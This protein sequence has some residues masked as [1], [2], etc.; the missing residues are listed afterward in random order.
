[1]KKKSTSQ[2]AFF[3]LRILVGV[4][5][6]LAGLSLALLATANPPGRSARAKRVVAPSPGKYKVTT[7]S[8]MDPLVP[9][10]F[11][12]SRIKQLG[13]DRQENFRAGAIMM[14]CGQFKGVKTSSH[15]SAFS[16]LV[17]NL[18][19]PLVY[20]ATDVDLITGDKSFPNVTQSETFT[21]ANPDDPSQVVVAYN[22]SRGRNF[23]P[24]NISGASFS[25]DGGTTFTRL[26]KA[27]GQSPFD[28]TFGDPV[29]LY[30][31]PSGTW[32][33][34]WL[35]GACGG[36]GLG[37]YSST[38][39]DD[40]DSW[41]HF[42]AFNEGS[43]DRESGWADNNPSSP[44]FGRL[45]ISWN[46]FNIGQGALMSIHSTDGGVTWSSPATVINGAT[47][48]RDV[49]ITGDLAGSGTVYIAGMDEGGGGFP[50]NDTNLIFKS[51]DG[52]TTWANTYTGTPFPGPGVTAQGYFA[53]M[54]PDNA[55]YWRHEGWG[56]PAAINNF[57]HLVYSQQGAPGDP[58]DVYYIRSTDG[59]VTFATPFKL[60]TDSTLRPQWQANLS[61]SPTGTLLATWY[62][63][64]ESTNCV[65]GDPNTPCYRMFSR[66]SNDNGASWLPDDMLSD[67]V[68]PLPGQPDPGIQ[69]TYAGDYDYGSAIASKHMTS[70]TDGRN[71]I[72]GQSQQDAFTDRD[73]VGFSVATAD[74]ACGSLVIGTTPTAFT[75][76]L[77]DPA[78]PATVQA[79]DFTVN[80]TPAD[81][82][83]L[84]NGNATIEFDFN[85]SPVT[86]GENT[87][88]I[89]AGAIHQASNND[90]I[91]EFNCTFRFAQ[92]QLTV[93]DT[94]PPVGGTF[95]PQ[96]PGTYT[97][98]V[99]W[100]IAVDPSSVTTSDLQVSGNAGATV[101]AVTVTGG[102][103]TTEFTL[104]IAFGGSLTAHIAA[105]AIT[106]TFGN[107]NT[108]FSGNYT[109]AGCPPSQYVIT[110]GADTIVPGDTDTG[111]HGDDVD[112]VVALPF[113]FQLYDQTFNSVN[114]SSNGRIDFVVAN[115]PGGFVT[116]CLP[117]P[118]NVGPYD[119]TIFPVWED[120]RTDFGLSGCANFPGGN[121][122]VFTSV[123]GTAPNR[124]FNIEWRTVLFADNAQTQN[125]EARL[126]ENGGPNN[127]LRF[128]VVI[129]TLNTTGAD[130]NYVSGVQ[131][132]SGAGFFTQ[133]FCANPAPVQN[134]SRAY[135]IPPCATPSPSPT[136]VP[137]ATPTVA[138][139]VTPSATP[140]ATPTATATTTP[141]PPPHHP[142]PRPRP[143]PHPRPT[144]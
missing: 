138:P 126:Y 90:P 53:C 60:N 143:T 125:F 92:E 64:R 94:D 49:Q 39:P 99:N 122:G 37:G 105:G 42:C 72:S 87:M 2:S 35:D 15:G 121:C 43:A 114:V 54:F 98:D 101:T 55:G 133:D 115:E 112:T 135:E 4:F 1:M 34:V 50:H 117:A 139:T 86:P 32:V 14:F 7:Q 8:S 56:E 48:I 93:T 136:V 141:T 27:N 78:D 73:L 25:T 119:F 83:T 62:D 144:P 118:P 61:V 33:T 134:V 57:V 41:T 109:V 30:H 16:K 91:L 142:T 11:D 88:H 6:A 111:N 123:S 107:P 130:H 80:G 12:C 120:M 52:G 3:N 20:G 66:K 63:A 19:A 104:Q 17:Q 5:V 51:T 84:S 103:T 69:P 137:S 140:S 124:I 76:D 89:D 47:F 110:D 96:A 131:G 13:I 132:N 70:W 106:D 18:T 65:A 67:V 40:P 127:D 82:F 23:N 97:Y 100:N 26:T 44:F 36:Q 24:I 102:G 129:G 108:D 68:T 31:K 75:I 21:T 116:A 59:G 46:D 113:P 81:S 22:D 128:D 29:I 77:S 9:A 45:Y 74:P 71:A 38:T 28:N 79:S 58:G 85:S 10:M 95:T